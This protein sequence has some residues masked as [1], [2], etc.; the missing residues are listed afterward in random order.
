MVPRRL[1]GG[2]GPGGPGRLR[3]P[4]LGGGGRR[5]HALPVD[6]RPQLRRGRAGE[7]VGHHRLRGAGRGGVRR[8]RAR[9][10]PPTPSPSPPP[11]RSGWRRSSRR[12]GSCWRRSPG[13][14]RPSCARAHGAAGGTGTGSWPTWR[15]PSSAT[16]ASS[17]PPQGSRR[18]PRR[19]RRGG[20]A[21]RPRSWRRCAR[22]GRASRWSTTVAA[23]LRRPPLRLARR[24]PRLGD[25]GPLRPRL[26]MAEETHA[27]AVVGGLDA[28]AV[29]AVVAVAVA[30]VQGRSRRGGPG[31]SPGAPVSNRC[32][33]PTQGACRQGGGRPRRRP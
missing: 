4:V 13:R 26:T 31:A 28:D 33:S 6:G 22:R 8:R 30:G 2:V 18:P 9:R 14:R 29:V 10:R 16:P 27:A 11:G 15:R 20:G 32:R 23:L 5:R 12:R 25:R 19:A 7:G 1:D 17:A 3:R 21:A 24:R